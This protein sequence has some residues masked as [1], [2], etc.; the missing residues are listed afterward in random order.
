PDFN[1]L[2]WPADPWYSGN[3][4]LK[5]ERSRNVEAHITFANDTTSASITAYQNQIRDMI[6][7]DATA[8]MPN[9]IN[10]AKIKGITLSAAH[11]YGAT[12]FHATADFMSPR[13]DKTGNLLPRRAKHVYNLGINHQ[14]NTWNVGAEY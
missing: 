3:P 2:Y 5:P 11:T 10:R 14:F 12:R 1:D 6:A 7:Y 8:G 9:N 13:D 4:N